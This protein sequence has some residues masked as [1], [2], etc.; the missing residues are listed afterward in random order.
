MKKFVAFFEGRIE[1][2]GLVLAGFSIAAMM[3]IEFLNAIG[4]KLYMPFPCTLETAESLMITTVFLGIGVVALTEEHTQV[5][6]I[7]RKMPKSVK[8]YLDAA[9]Y[10]FAA[11]LFGFLTLGAWPIAWDSTLMLEI[12]IGVYHFPIWVFKIFYALGLTLMFI[13]SVINAIRFISQAADPT[14][15]PED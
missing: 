9:A 11:G 6:I 5:T 8:R 2:I 7:T 14:W 10:L 13:Q 4:R 12:R 1:R 3:I 15:N